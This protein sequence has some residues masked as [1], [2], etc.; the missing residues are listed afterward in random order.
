MKKPPLL[1][2]LIRIERRGALS[3]EGSP[4]W[5]DEADSWDEENSAWIDG[6]G[7]G[8]GNFE[9]AWRLFLG[10]IHAA[11]EPRRGGES[12]IAGRLQ[13]V[14]A[15]DVWVRATPETAAIAVTDRVVDARDLSRIYAIRFIENLDMRDRYLLL[16]CEAGVAD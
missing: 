15:F 5:Q 12:V 9:T 14:S 6:D 16:Q 1:R 2:R 10:P 8:A 7:D 4:A 11:I 13:G 3:Q